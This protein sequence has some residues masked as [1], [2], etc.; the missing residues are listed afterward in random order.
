MFQELGGE[1]FTCWYDPDGPAGYDP[2]D[3]WTNEDPGNGDT[4]DPGYVII[5]IGWVMLGKQRLVHAMTTAITIV[6]NL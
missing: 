4:D 2:N 6:C 3:G 5:Q 1:E